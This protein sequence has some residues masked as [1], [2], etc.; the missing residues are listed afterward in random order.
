MSPRACHLIRVLEHVCALRLLRYHSAARAR[1]SIPSFDWLAATRY[2][3]GPLEIT[4][5]HFLLHKLILL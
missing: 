3:E 5:L 4:Y 2:T 1:A